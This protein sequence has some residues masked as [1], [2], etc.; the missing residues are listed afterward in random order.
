M[1][2]VLVRKKRSIKKNCPITNLRPSLLD[3]LL[4]HIYQ[5]QHQPF[6]SLKYNL[7]LQIEN[8]IIKN[9]TVKMNMRRCQIVEKRVS[10]V[11]KM[12]DDGKSDKFHVHQ[13]LILA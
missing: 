8:K 12:K 13:K 6:V 5:N 4:D 1:V 10:H 7:P 9:Q 11:S 2:P 3:N